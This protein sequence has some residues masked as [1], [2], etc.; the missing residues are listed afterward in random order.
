MI[1]IMSKRVLVSL[2]LIVGA[3]IGGYVPLLFGAG[4]FSYTSILASGLGAILGVWIGFK[5]GD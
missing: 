4:L 1:R 3:T 2:G 5:L